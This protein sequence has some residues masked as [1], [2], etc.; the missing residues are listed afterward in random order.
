MDLSFAKYIYKSILMFF[1]TD[2]V[3]T[4]LINLFYLPFRQGCKF[5]ILLFHSKLSIRKDSRIIIDCDDSDC[6]FGMIKLG[7]KH[8]GNVLTC[9]GI[10]LNLQSG[11]LIFKGAGI[12][13][14][15]CC[16]QTLGGTIQFGKNFGI[17]GDFTICSENKIDI[18]PNFSSS[19]DVSIYDTDFHD[20][21][22]VD[23][24]NQ[25]PKTLPI[26]I[27]SNSWICQRVT[28]LKGTILPEWSVVAA[29]TVANKDFS[30]CLSYT[31]FAGVPAKA[32]TKR[33]Q[34][35]DIARISQL[36]KWNITRGFNV[37]SPMNYK[38]K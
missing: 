13:G 3:N 38:D 28:I 2:W 4:S 25:M 16:I 5:P 14:N 10:N 35:I 32:I 17:T 12:M 18:G 24:G 34:R 37:F 31:V 15:G 33:I 27:G 29:G 21:I 9:S 8:S 36:K 1:K 6:H 22:D 19:W 20:Y 7:L 26:Q 11:E 30:K 23:T